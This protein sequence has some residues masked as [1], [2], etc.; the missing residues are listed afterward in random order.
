M[1]K[2]AFILSFLLVA[3]L[4]SAQQKRLENRQPK[5]PEQ[6]AEGITKSL[7]KR[8]S[9]TAEQS[10]NIKDINLA[11]A[12]KVDALRADAKAQRANKTFD[13][14]AFREQMMQVQKERDAQITAQLNDTQKT[15]YQDMKNKAQERSKKRMQERRS[16]ADKM[17]K[18][19]KNPKN[20]K[21]K[22]PQE[23]DSDDAELEDALDDFFEEI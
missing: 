6:R 2:I 17:K 9:L 8:L 11:A 4:A 5:T 10:A 12:Q 18:D 15:S 21:S 20:K 23:N 1:R 22:E 13:A 19:R 16:K 7:N 14:K 3:G